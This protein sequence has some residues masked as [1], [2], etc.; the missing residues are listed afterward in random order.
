LLTRHRKEASL[1]RAGKKRAK[2]TAG[3]IQPTLFAGYDVISKCGKI[4]SLGNMLGRQS[5]WYQLNY[6]V[7]NQYVPE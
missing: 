5:T 7:S 1:N 6:F 3:N 4:I 2:D